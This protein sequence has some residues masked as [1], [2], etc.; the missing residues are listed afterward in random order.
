MGKWVRF[1]GLFRRVRSCDVVQ[2]IRSL[3]SLAHTDMSSLYSG[4]LSPYQFSWWRLKSPGIRQLRVGVW[5][6]VNFLVSFLGGVYVYDLRSS[7]VYY[8]CYGDDPVGVS[9]EPGVVG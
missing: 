7:V 4:A 8:Y 3:A 5:V 1:P 6:Y 9:L 2:L